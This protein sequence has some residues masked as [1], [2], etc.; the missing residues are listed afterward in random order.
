MITTNDELRAELDVLRAEAQEL[1]ALSTR[2]GALEGE[3][4]TRFDTVADRIDEI[5]AELAQRDKRQAQLRALADTPG[6]TERGSDPGVIHRDRSPRDSVRDNALRTIERSEQSGDLPD[7]AAETAERLTR[8]DSF[9]ARWV[10]VTGSDSYREAFSKMLR[11]PSKG[12]LLWTPQEHQAWRDVAAIASERSLLES[13]TGS[14]LLPF[15]LD[16]TILLTNNG[17]VN[18]I[19]QI[20]RVVQVTSNAWHG[21]TSAGVSTAWIPEANVVSENSPTLAQ[22]EIPVHKGAAFTAFSIEQFEDSANLL[23]ELGKLLADAKDQLE[24]I[25]FITGDGT[26]KPKGI[27]TALAAASPSV[28]VNGT[29]TEAL[30]AADAYA[31][32]NALPPRFSPNA[33]WAMALPTINQF[34]QFETANGSLKF[35]GM[36][37]NPR[38]LLGRGVNEFSTMD[39]AVNATATETNYLAIYGD[40]KAGFV[41]ADRIGASVE[42]VP[43]VFSNPSGTA[44]SPTGERGVFFHWRTGA[45]AVI[46]NA[47]RMLNVPTTA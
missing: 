5:K 30:A 25:A 19:R 22:P 20:A 39:S 47:F 28:I 44:V 18:P 13:G 32:Q 16:P 11:D 14:A 17:S 35:P 41:V 23:A 26:N 12:H 37:S 7:H 34:A 6:L 36:Q 46:P 45:D 38:T 33:Q 8:A 9:A 10:A 4:A 40:F 21:V 27:V 2:G 24:A 29:G 42:L 43:H 1:A 31:V 15:Q 3:D